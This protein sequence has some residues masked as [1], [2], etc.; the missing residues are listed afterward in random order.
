MKR[1]PEKFGVLELF[2]ALARVNNL[3]LD[4]DQDLIQF[5]KITLNSLT[6]TRRADTILHGKRVEAMFAYIAGALGR[7]RLIK[8]EDGGDLFVSGL[9]MQAPDYRLVLHDGTVML[10]EVK[11]FHFTSFDECF[12]INENYLETLER[13]AEAQGLNLKVAVYFSRI[14]MWCLLSRDAFVRTG[15]CF[16]ITVLSAIAKNEMYTL[17]DVSI[18]TLPQLSLELMGDSDNANEIDI[19]GDASV[20]FKTAKLFCDGNELLDEL[21]QRIAFYL[22]KYGRWRQSCQPIIDNNRLLGLLFTSCPDEVPSGQPFAIVA[23]MSSMISQAYSEYT[24]ANGKPIAIDVIGDPDEFSLCIPLNFNSTL[25]PL[26]RFVLH[27]NP[28]FIDTY[29]E[30]LGPVGT[31]SKTRT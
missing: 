26:W 24:V 27:P 22:M 2:S 15:K 6:T 21:D 18:A 30:P 8:T 14:K 20:T 5:G 19:N 23:E 10:V 25:L 11:N 12:S 31:S 28:N 17:G 3:K 1:D 16:T 4:S 13:Y 7:C 29:F 9:P